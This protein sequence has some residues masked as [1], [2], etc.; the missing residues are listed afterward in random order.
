LF[1][2][3]GEAECPGIFNERLFDF[4]VE[5]DGTLWGLA[6]IAGVI[7]GFQKRHSSRRDWPWL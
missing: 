6:G 5:K 3:E 2:P 1:A 7:L 4:R